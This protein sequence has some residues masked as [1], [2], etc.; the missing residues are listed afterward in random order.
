MKKRTYKRVKSPMKLSSSLQDELANNANHL[1]YVQ[2]GQDVI[3]RGTG[4]KIQQIAGNPVFTSQFDI[5]IS[6][7]YSKLNYLSDAG[8]AGVPFITYIDY[9]AVAPESLPQNLKVDVP[10]FLF[11]NADFASGFK[12]SKANM[13][14]SNWR[15]MSPKIVKSD[16]EDFFIPLSTF[17]GQ[18]APINY[19]S[20]SVDN[21]GAAIGDLIIPLYYQTGQVGGPP[22]SEIY[23]C[24]VIV[25]CKQVGYGTLLDAISSDRF[26]F[27]AVR[28]KIP[29]STKTAQY[30]KQLLLIKQSLFGKLST[31]NISPVSFQLPTSFQNNLIDVPLTKG[32]DKE[33]MVGTFLN[34]DV[35][36]INLSFFVPVQNKL[37]QNV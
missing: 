24:E 25:N 18:Q 10:A 31:D 19:Q 15:Y 26:T 22:P 37:T 33:S 16:A 8:V 14:V 29:D 27:S 23:L 36:E 28:Y 6:I 2:G 13:A 34:Y 35:G 30:E 7:R 17:E 12:N 3:S 11:G 5:N 9:N 4:A 20:P 21:G 32:V 1:E